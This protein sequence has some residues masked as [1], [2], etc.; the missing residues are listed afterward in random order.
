MIRHH[1]KPINQP[2]P[3]LC[4]KIFKNKLTL[5][6]HMNSKQCLKNKKYPF[7][8]A[9]MLLMNDVPDVDDATWKITKISWVI[10]IKI[11]L[12]WRIHQMLSPISNYKS[13]NFFRFFSADKLRK[14]CFWPIRILFS[15]SNA[16]TEKNPW[17]KLV[18]LI[19]E[20]IWWIRWTKRI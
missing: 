11:L 2:C 7:L 16:Q 3:F 6:Q 8:D 13:T 19:G 9:S 14:H 15:F 12:Y 1:A 10:A 20:E 18:N 5:S 4:G 17:K